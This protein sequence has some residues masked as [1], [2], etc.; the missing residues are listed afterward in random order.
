M[1]CIATLQENYSAETYT[2]KPHEIML[3]LQ[4]LFDAREIV[5]FQYLLIN[6]KL[7]ALTL[8]EDIYQFFSHLFLQQTHN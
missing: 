4:D 6:M 1:Y 2:N 7:E 5:T 3:Q 8:Q